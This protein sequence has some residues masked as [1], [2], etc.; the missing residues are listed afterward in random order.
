MSL[1]TINIFQKLFWNTKIFHY[2]LYYWGKVN[3]MFRNPAYVFVFISLA[4]CYYDHRDFEDSFTLAF[5]CRLLLHICIPVDW[6]LCIFI[7]FFK[8]TTWMLFP[9]QSKQPL[10]FF[11]W[12]NLLEDVET[13][14]I[15]WTAFVSKLIRENVVITC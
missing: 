10:F 14:L 11:L 13:S 9:L 12:K 3:K 6:V 2:F 5:A 8:G 4:G 7:V 1:Y 15:K